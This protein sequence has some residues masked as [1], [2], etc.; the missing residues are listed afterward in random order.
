M[1]K[2]TNQT[3]RQ[4]YEGPDGVQGNNS[5]TAFYAKRRYGTQAADQTGQYQFAALDNIINQFMIVYVGEDKLISSARKTDVAFHAQRGL[6]ELNYDTLKS[7]N[8]FSFVV[9]P[10]LNFSLPKDY[11]N[12]TKVCLLDTSGIE[13]IIY[14]TSKTSNPGQL[15]QNDDGSFKYEDNIWKDP[16]DGLYK[17]YGINASSK[18]SADSKWESQ[19]PLRKYRYE[20][21]VDV[22]GDSRILPNSGATS[23]SYVFYGGGGATDMKMFFHGDYPDMKVGQTVFGPGIPANTTVASVTENTTSNYRGT[24]L[25]L[26]NP[27]Y[28]ADLL[29]DSPTGTAGRPTILSLNISDVEV[30]VVDLNM[31]SDAW[32]RYKSHTPTTNTDDYEDDTRWHA[33]GRRYGIDPQHAQDNGS[34]YIDQN[35]G[36]IHFSSALSG[37]TVVLHYITDGLNPTG[38]KIHKFAEE[39][40]YRYIAH[41][42]LAGK[43]NVPEYVVRRLKKEKFA[44]MRQAKLRLSNL[45]LEELSQT[46]R[47]KSKQIK[48]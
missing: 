26:T 41:A 19:S 14:P 5:R 28:E 24:E 48:H 22:T 29:L 2:L 25:T 18:T 1:G 31:T 45:K 13:K 12:Y 42:I 20:T 9:P 40:M 34:Y 43:A 6:A 16:V 47:G 38:P 3:Q 4:Y 32:E 37:Q 8:S 39:A 23:T 15:Q 30:I 44:A 36:L 7:N 33:E 35:T 10:S 17:E 21:R 11:V 27:E 46:L